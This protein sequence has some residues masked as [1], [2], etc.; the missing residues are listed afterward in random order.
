MAQTRE[1]RAILQLTGNPTL[2]VAL[3]K[4]DRVD[5]ARIQEVQQQVQ[6]VLSDYGFAQATLFV[7]AANEGLGI[8]ALRE[9]LLQLPAREHARIRRSDWLSTAPL[10]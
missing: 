4:A 10:L 1:H 9:H 3:T 5:D 7:T 2:T 8:D 6:D